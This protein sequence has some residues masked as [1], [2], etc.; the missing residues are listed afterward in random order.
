MNAQGFAGHLNV[1][2][3]K[4]LHIL[5]DFASC[6]W[7]ILD[8][9][10]GL[11]SYKTGVVIPAKEAY[12]KAQLHATCW[13]TAGSNFRLEEDTLHHVQPRNCLQS[14]IRRFHMQSPSGSLLT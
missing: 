8:K 9:C 12:D 7:V 2:S 13:R 10:L 6:L 14:H 11:S 5:G 4:G 1:A 3:R